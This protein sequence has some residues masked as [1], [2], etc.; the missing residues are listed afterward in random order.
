[1]KALSDN[2][3]YILAYLNFKNRIDMYWKLCIIVLL[4]LG[5]CN[6]T[7][8]V[9]EVKRSNDS[10]AITGE[11]SSERIVFVNLK[12]KRDSVSGKNNI[13]LINKTFTTGHLKNGM[14]GNGRSNNYLTCILYEDKLA[15]DTIRLDHPLY[16]TF[17]Y[18]NEKNEMTLKQMDVKEAE[19]FLRFQLKGKKSRYITADSPGRLSIAGIGSPTILFLLAS[20]AAGSKGATNISTHTTLLISTCSVKTFPFA[21][22]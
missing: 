13:E 5:S 11:V 22:V 2:I 7:R 1:M 20:S 12:I 21:S 9:K 16:K 4:I 14:K 8:P 18:M 3:I 6:S 10:I 15:S 17:E 19:F